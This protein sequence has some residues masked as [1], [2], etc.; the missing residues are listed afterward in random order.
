MRIQP[1]GGEPPGKNF[2][3]DSDSGDGGVRPYRLQAAPPEERVRPIWTN[4]PERLHSFGTY[5]LL[6]T[7][8]LC[9]VQR[10]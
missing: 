3:K 2:D 8:Y 1:G 5:H 9:T 7:A 10:F 4:D 6:D